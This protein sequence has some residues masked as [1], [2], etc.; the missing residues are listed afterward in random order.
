M[1]TIKLISGFI[2]GFFAGILICG[3]FNLSQDTPKS[4]QYSIR[5]KLQGGN[6]DKE[7]NTS[8]FDTIP[9]ESIYFDPLKSK[10]NKIY[11]RC[12]FVPY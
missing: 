10:N 7:W 4:D 3:V 6:D 9:L 12:R 1:E 5:Y 2:I 11:V 8:E